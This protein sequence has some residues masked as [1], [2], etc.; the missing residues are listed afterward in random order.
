MRT[1]CGKHRKQALQPALEAA[2]LDLLWAP[3]ERGHAMYVLI[4]IIGTAPSAGTAYG[5]VNTY[6]MGQFETRYACEYA[7]RDHSHAQIV[8][9]LRYGADW[10]CTK[11]GDPIDWIR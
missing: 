7:A 4:I 9:G 2:F 6:I 5:P 10:L 3:I 1:E 11:V 8:A